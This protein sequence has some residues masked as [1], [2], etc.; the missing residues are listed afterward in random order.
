M[1]RGLPRQDLAPVFPRRLRTPDRQCPPHPLMP[2]TARSRR[3]VD[4]ASG[5]APRDHQL[6]TINPATLMTIPTEPHFWTWTPGS[7]QD[8]SQSVWGWREARLIV[9]TVRGRKMRDTASL[10]DEFAAALQFPP[11][12]GE[13]WAAFDE[14]LTD[15]AWL[16]HEEGYVIV[17][18]DPLLVLDASPMDFPVLVRTLKQAITTWA[19][20]VALGEWWDRPPVP[21]NVIL[22]T[23][24]WELEAVVSRW[25]SAGGHSLALR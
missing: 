21:F 1:F 15:L 6:V 2:P 5:P 16:P 13:N 9:R 4:V 7:D 23:T 10:D 19:T 22:W 8:A 18:T 11:Y 17:V 14:C 24:D 3:F 20:P 12:F 25:A